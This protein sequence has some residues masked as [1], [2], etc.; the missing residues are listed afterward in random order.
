MSSVS[1]RLQP[2]LSCGY[3]TD[4]NK[5]KRRYCYLPFCS[6]NWF[7]PSG[8]LD[9]RAGTD[10]TGANL[11]TPHLAVFQR[12]HPLQI[13]IKTPFGL[14][15]GMANIIAHLGPFATFFTYLAHVV[16]LLANCLHAVKI[17][18]NANIPK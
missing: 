16:I 9:H 15:V 1:K 12:A 8:R 17:S 5:K 13:G 10:T 4:N 6:N 11:D 3:S 2:D 14:V 7:E 18:K